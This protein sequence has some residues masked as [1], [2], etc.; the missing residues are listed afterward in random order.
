MKNINTNIYGDQMLELSKTTNWS[1]NIWAWV[2]VGGESG[3]NSRPCSEEWVIHLRDRCVA[4]G[5][6]F[7][8]KQWGGRFRKRNGSL[9]QGQ[10]YH[11]MP[12]SIQAIYNSD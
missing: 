7:T 9:L 10:Y 2:V 11:E 5:V 4:Q 3:T 8:F 6:A 1:E 12:V